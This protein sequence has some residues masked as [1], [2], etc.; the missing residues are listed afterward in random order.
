[1]QKKIVALIVFLFI[2]IQQSSALSFEKLDPLGEQKTL[3][4]LYNFQNAPND[5]PFT[6]QQVSDALFTAPNSMN[7]FFKEN[8]YGKT[9]F[10]GKIAGWYTVP[11]DNGPYC[12]DGR[13]DALRL[14][15]A[16][17]IHTKDYERWIFIHAEMPNCDPTAG[18]IGGNPSESSIEASLSLYLYAHEVG[19]NMGL[20]HA[21]SLSCGNKSIDLYSNCNVI[22]YGDFLGS[23][24]HNAGTSHLNVSQKLTMGWLDQNQVPEI[25]QSGTYTIIPLAKN[26]TAVKGF[27]IRKYNT[28]EYYFIEYRQPISGTFDQNLSP[29]VTKGAIIHIGYFIPHGNGG[30]IP[31]TYLLDS[32]PPYAGDI[33]DVA[34]TEG[35]TFVDDIN[36]IRITQ[37]SHDAN[38]LVVNVIVPEVIPSRIELNL[39]GISTAVNTA[40]QLSALV[41]DQNNKPIWS[42]VSYEWG[43]SSTNSIGTLIQINGNLATFLAQNPGSGDLWVKAT[44]NGQTVVKSI[45]V[46]VTTVTPSPSP[47]FNALDLKTLLLKYA[48]NQDSLYQPR[49]NKVNMLDAGYVIRYLQ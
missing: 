34:L 3:V 46:T 39:G 26:D 12:I 21:H 28:D 1:M 27:R 7:A 41:Y 42:S 45:P 33:Q 13:N 35:N 43:I 37:V 24:G 22:N 8:S 31:E 18:E 47:I 14:A 5:K 16:N 19:H 36:N 11:F 9:F 44:F 4:I 6:L 38:S 48:T 17:G 29:T 10:T 25:T 40:S 23:M 32:S 49:D 30:E 20:G 15:E 2:F